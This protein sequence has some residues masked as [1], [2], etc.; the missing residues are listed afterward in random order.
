M[1]KL[2]PSS[3]GALQL[4]YDPEMGE[5]QGTDSP[6]SRGVLF[7]APRPACLAS[8]GGTR[9]G[10]AGKTVSGH[11]HPGNRVQVELHSSASAPLFSLPFPCCVVWRTFFV[12]GWAWC[13]VGQGSPGLREPSDHLLS[14]SLLT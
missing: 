2:D 14:L 9:T 6:S 1:A 7:T 4:P 8:L 12:S 13:E 11:A 3:Q 5:H 10:R